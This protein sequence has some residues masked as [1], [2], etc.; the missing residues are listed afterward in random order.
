MPSTRTKTPSRTQT[1]TT[2]VLDA[3][4]FDAPELECSERRVGGAAGDPLPLPAARVRQ[5][6]PQVI[7]QAL[8]QARLRR[9][10]AGMS[11]PARGELI[12]ALLE[13]LRAERDELPDELRERLLDGM[14]DE[15]IVGKRTEREILGRDGVLGE[16][17]RRMVQ[18]AL[19][20][21]L[22]EHLGYPAGQAPLGGVGNSRN[23]GTPKTLLTDHGRWRS[24]RRATATATLSRS[25]SQSTSGGWPA[26]A[27]RSSPCT[28]AA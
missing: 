22:A 24:V 27:R 1:Q 6:S 3:D 4:E 25:W 28:P 18:R 19:S 26:S 13:Q 8:G 2:A 23:G 21:E 5:P 16:I 12:D 20:E 14:I 10:L 17:T 11:D 15:L 9:S 7:E